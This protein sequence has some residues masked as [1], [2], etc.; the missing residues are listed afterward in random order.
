[1]FRDKI[2]EYKIEINRLYSMK[3]KKERPEEW[4]LWIM[5]HIKYEYKEINRYKKMIERIRKFNKPEIDDQYINIQEVLNKVDP[6][7]LIGG[8]VKLV[9]SGNKEWKGL[10]PFHNERTPSFFVNEDTGLYHC[11]GCGASGNSLTFVIKYEGF[12]IK[13]ALDYLN[14]RY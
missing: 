3:E 13:K 9:K 4:E 6:I 12:H 8:F 1:M 7:D 5:P 11:F 2:D 14:K 10:C